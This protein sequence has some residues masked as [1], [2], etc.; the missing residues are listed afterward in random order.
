MDE[1]NFLKVI[2]FSE[3]KTKEPDFKY[4]FV[5]F[6]DCKTK[7]IGE[8]PVY[9]KSFILDDIDKFDTDF[10]KMRVWPGKIVLHQGVN[11]VVF[12]EEYEHEQI[13]LKKAIEHAKKRAIK[14]PRRRFSV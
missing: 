13:I 12:L 10:N 9:P 6:Q 4:R 3:I 5:T 8:R 7:L 11:C 1:I 14:Y 2:D